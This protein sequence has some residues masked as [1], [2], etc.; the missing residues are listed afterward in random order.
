MKFFM[1]LILLYE[2]SK[3]HWYFKAHLVTTEQNISFIYSI[4]IVLV[5]TQTLVYMYRNIQI[6]Y[7]RFVGKRYKSRPNI[8]PLI[9]QAKPLIKRQMMPPETFNKLWE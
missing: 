2:N 9:N 1:A 7:E 8:V 3:Y 6:I 5:K 4:S